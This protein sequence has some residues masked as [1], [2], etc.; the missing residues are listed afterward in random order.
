MAL[1]IQIFIRIS[2]YGDRSIYSIKFTNNAR[3]RL[4]LSYSKVNNIFENELFKSKR[5]HLKESIIVYLIVSR[6][7]TAPN[8]LPR[9]RAFWISFEFVQ[10][11]CYR[12]HPPN[13]IR[14][15]RTYVTFGTWNLCVDKMYLNVNNSHFRIDPLCYEWEAGYTIYRKGVAN[16]RRA[17][18]TL[19]F[20]L[21][22]E[23]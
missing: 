16:L 10:K 19:V 9:G 6:V 18:D 8:Y 7:I 15:H 11:K 22:D 23:P 5:R 13:R 2:Y 4:F 3:P 14:L 12:S 17:I 1:Q 20:I 21:I